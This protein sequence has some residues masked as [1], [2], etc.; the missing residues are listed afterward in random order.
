MKAPCRTCLVNHPVYLLCTV[1]CIQVESTHKLLNFLKVSLYKIARTVYASAFNTAITYYTYTFSSRSNSFSS[2]NNNNLTK[3][4]QSVQ[5]QKKN[6]NSGKI[7][8]IQ[9]LIEHNTL[10]FS[11]QMLTFCYPLWH[12]KTCM[13]FLVYAYC[14][15]YL[16]WI[17]L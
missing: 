1:I 5:A 8:V 15:T 4:D 6:N 7:G 14:I 16:P 12:N 13:E 11:T 2:K 3:Y 10:P 17:R 9:N